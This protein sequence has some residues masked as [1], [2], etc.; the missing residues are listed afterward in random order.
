MNRNELTVIA[1][2]DI[3]RNSTEVSPETRLRHLLHVTS[4][5]LGNAQGV[6]TE[7]YSEFEGSVVN[8]A[9]VKEEAKKGFT[10]RCGWPEFLE[11]MW[12]LQHYLEHARRICEGK[13]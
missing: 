11:K 3:E 13:T 9:M 4:S 1:G 10:P 6:W 12:L 5:M 8:G 7:L 2:G